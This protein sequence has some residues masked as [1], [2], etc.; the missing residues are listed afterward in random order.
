MRFRNGATICA[1]RDQIS[2]QVSMNVYR[3]LV[4]V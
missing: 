1:L 3:D 2:K 4:R